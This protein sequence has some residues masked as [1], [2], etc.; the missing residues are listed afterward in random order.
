MADEGPAWRRH[1]RYHA[2]ART[3]GG[4]RLGRNLRGG[5]WGLPTVA[6]GRVVRRPRGAGPVAPQTARRIGTRVAAGVEED[7]LQQRKPLRAFLAVRRKAGGSSAPEHGPAVGRRTGPSAAPLQH[8]PHAPCLH[9]RAM[10]RCV[11]LAARRDLVQPPDSVVREGGAQDFGSDA[12]SNGG[13]DSE[14]K[15]HRPPRTPSPASWLPRTPRTHRASEHAPLPPAIP[16]PRIPGGVRVVDVVA[17]WES[18]LPAGA[19]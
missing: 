3:P 7:G 2:R 1:R 6:A 11:W 12:D 19:G 17:S 8:S 16:H 10:L 14:A 15:N 5:C 13:G 9:A 4:A 18:H